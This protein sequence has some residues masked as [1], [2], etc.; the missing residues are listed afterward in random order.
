MAAQINPKVA[1]EKGYFIPGQNFKPDDQIQQIGIDVTLKLDK[2]VRLFPKSYLNLDINEGVNLPNNVYADMKQRSSFS[3][4]GVFTTN[5]FYDPGFH[6]VCGL[7]IYNLSDDVIELEPNVRVAQMVF[8]EA[9]AASSYDGHY[10]HS[11]T[12]ASQFDT[13]GEQKNVSN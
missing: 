7:S 3:R 4:K 11:S 13:K 8:F 5:G 6:G 1:I 10:N 12:S 9:D 2:T